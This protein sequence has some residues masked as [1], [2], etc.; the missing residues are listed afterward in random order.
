MSVLSGNYTVV[1]NSLSVG[2]VADGVEHDGPG[3]GDFDDIRGD[4][5]GPGAT[6]GG[7]TQGGNLFV[8]MLL[9]EWNA[10]AAMRIMEPQAIGTGTPGL[11]IQPGL[12]ISTFAA[13]L[14]LTKVSGTNAVPAT[15]RTYTYAVPMVNQRTAY[16]FNHRKRFVPIQFQILPYTSSGNKYYVDV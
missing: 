13:A 2:Q 8:R 4:N 1:W 16:A 14:V 7:V 10:A 15:T 12:L 11:A 5:F 3:L 6:Q 9:M